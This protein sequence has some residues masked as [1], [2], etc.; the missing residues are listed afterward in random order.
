MKSPRAQ[1][2]PPEPQPGLFRSSRLLPPHGPLHQELDLNVQGDRLAAPSPHHSPTLT[3]WLSPPWAPCLPPAAPSLC[4]ALGLA[5]AP[6]PHPCSLEPRHTLGV[7][8]GGAVLLLAWP[9]LSPLPSIP[10]P[11][12]WH[13]GQNCG[14][15]AAGQEPSWGRCQDLDSQ[16]GVGRSDT[17]FL[18]EEAQGG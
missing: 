11:T 3:R 4:T 17:P 14:S 15:Q 7:G 2:S 5:E 12:A 9:L 8:A 18:S 16:K 6:P 13:R 10:L 1:P